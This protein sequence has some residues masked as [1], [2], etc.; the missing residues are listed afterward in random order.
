V[1]PAT[2]NWPVF[3]AALLLM[4][5]PLAHIGWRAVTSRREVGTG[6]RFGTALS[7]YE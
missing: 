4:A 1:L 5:A 3:A 2:F 7:R 6:R